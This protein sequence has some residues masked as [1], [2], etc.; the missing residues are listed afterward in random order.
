MGH[1]NYGGDE[2]VELAHGKGGAWGKEFKIGANTA[3]FLHFF[4]NGHLWMGR[5]FSSVESVHGVDGM[6]SKKVGQNAS[7]ADERGKY[8][9]R[10]GRH[11]V[12]WKMLS[13]PMENP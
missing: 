9:T 4:A 1:K 6:D 3:F 12:Q 13:V 11:G 2:E 10:T 8:E 7:G 5:T